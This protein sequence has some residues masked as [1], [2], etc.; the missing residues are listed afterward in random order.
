[1]LVCAFFVR[2]CTR[3]R[4]CSADPAFPAP[5]AYREGEDGT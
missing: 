4:G 2:K 1:M 5:S 3:D